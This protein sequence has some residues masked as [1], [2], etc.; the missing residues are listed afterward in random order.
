[1]AIGGVIN[2]V[3]ETYNQFMQEE[4]MEISIN[5]GFTMKAKLYIQRLK[6]LMFLLWHIL[7][8]EIHFKAKIDIFSFYV[9]QSFSAGYKILKLNLFISF[10]HENI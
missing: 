10:D 2:P 3:M 8:Q 7:T 1:M 5:S 4:S 9:D 6:K